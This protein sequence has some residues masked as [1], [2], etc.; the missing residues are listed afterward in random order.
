V[1]QSEK[2]DKDGSFIKK[3]IPKLAPLSGKE[4]HQP[5]V[6]FEKKGDAFP[7]RLGIDYPF[8]IVDHR[9]QRD[10]ALSMYKAC[11]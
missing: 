11:K 6:Y 3:Y 8:P 4:I 2:F 9:K 10:L 1:L 5:W 7:I